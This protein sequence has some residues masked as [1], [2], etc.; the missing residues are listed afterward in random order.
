MCRYHPRSSSHFSHRF[1]NR[2]QTAKNRSPCK[3]S[4][5]MGIPLKIAGKTDKGRRRS[6]KE[7]SFCVDTDLGF[8]IV[9]DGMGGHASGEVAS[10][11]AT[12]LCSSQLKRSL[13]TGHVPIF[14][15]VPPDPKLDPRSRILGD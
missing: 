7:D 3:T 9:A 2:L 8:V 10:Q 5:A 15:H 12:S 14:Y 4:L 6:K 11:L 13:Q 1:P